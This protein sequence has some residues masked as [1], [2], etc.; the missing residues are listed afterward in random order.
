MMQD[1]DFLQDDIDTEKTVAYIK[2]YL[3]Q[4][5]K[6]KYSDEE[7]YYFLDLMDDYYA[8]SGILDAEPDADGTVEIDLEEIAEYIVEQ[9]QQDEMGTY[10]PEEVLFVVQG[11][12]EYVESLDNEE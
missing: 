3:P 7:L 11:E 12:W 2:N 8:E 6:G 4:E 1:D 5:I 9:A 10:D